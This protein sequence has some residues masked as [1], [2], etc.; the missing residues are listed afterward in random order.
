MDE[1]CTRW[2]NETVLDRGRFAL[3]EWGDNRVP[4]QGGLC[5]DSMKEAHNSS[6][7]EHAG[8]ARMFSLLSHIYFWT[9]MEDDIESYIKICHVFQVDKT[10]H[11]KE[12][13]LLQTLPILE[14][15]WLSK[16]MN[17]ISGFTKVDS[18]ASIIIVVDF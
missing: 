6:C 13:G 3:F 10:K 2:H 15:P 12:A 5:K 8:G 17:F 16:S 7:A 4:N 18:K 9:K 14:R 1:S 11:K